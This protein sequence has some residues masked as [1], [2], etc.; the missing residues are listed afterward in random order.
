MRKL[1]RLFFRMLRYRVALMLLLF[2]LL[3]L[4]AGRAITVFSFNYVWAALALCS[5][6]VAATTINDIADKKIDIINHPASQGR[7]L[8]TGEAAE[9]DL[10]EVH[11]LAAAVTLIFAALIGAKAAG[12]LCLSLLIN[13]AYSLPPLRLSYRTHFAPIILSVAYV[14]IPFWLGTFVAHYTI[15]IGERFLAASLLCLFCGRIILKDFRDRKGDALYGKPTFLLKYGK[16]ATCALSLVS[17]VFGNFLLFWSLRTA[18]P[19]ILLILEIYFVCIALMLYK[20]FRSREHEQEQTA[21]GI[22]AKMGNGLLLT[23]L[24]LL[25]LM[26]YQSPASNQ[27]AFVG[28]ITAIFLFNFFLLAK[29]PERAIIGYRG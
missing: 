19:I 13:Y 21:I 10:Y 22:G 5:S 9:K 25:I 7:P 18:S 20:L 1:L 12:I 26:R 14:L 3:G 27:I 8:V 15:G 29:K 6:Y 24:G 17:I 23:T 2:F 28:A 11:A 16:G 4:A